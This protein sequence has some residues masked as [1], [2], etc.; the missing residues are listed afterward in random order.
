[1]ST[2]VTPA[3]QMFCEFK[4]GINGSFFTSLIETMFL[5]DRKNMV[6]LGKGF[7]ELTDVV[8]RYGREEK[9]YEDLVQRWNNNR[10]NSKLQ[11]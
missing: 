4:L 9:Y 6:L 10:N 7:P 2:I 5:A 11:Y 1:M 8:E 3:E